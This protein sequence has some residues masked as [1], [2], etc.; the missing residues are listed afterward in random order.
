MSFSDFRSEFRS[1]MKSIKQAGLK[2][3]VFAYELENIRKTGTPL[4]Q[5]L[6]EFAAGNRSK[7]S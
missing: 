1:L 7:L 4:N 5:L 6:E 3:D 2:L